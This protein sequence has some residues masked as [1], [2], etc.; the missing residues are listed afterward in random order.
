LATELV[1]TYGA[2][3]ETA[4]AYALKQE[5]NADLLARLDTL[6]SALAADRLDPAEYLTLAG[7]DSQNYKTKFPLLQ[8]A[9]QEHEKSGNAG[10]L[11]SFFAGYLEFK[12]G[13]H[14]ERKISEGY[15]HLLLQPLAA[16]LQ[17]SAQPD[18]TLMVMLAEAAPLDRQIALDL[19][20]R[21]LCA[22]KHGNINLVHLLAKQGAD[23]TT[24]SHQ[25]LVNALRA[26]HTDIALMLVREHGANPAEA[27]FD[28]QVNTPSETTLIQR[29]YQCM[30]ATYVPPSQQAPRLTDMKRLPKAGR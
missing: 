6:R 18:E 22:E 14:S 29:I 17:K 3:T 9:L 30:A 24:M 27:L 8:R 23:A 21:H 11:Q 20:L 26:G 2:D 13:Q 4:R 7:S 1:I 16:V 15:T 12:R 10:L 25:P 5:K 28:T 19:M